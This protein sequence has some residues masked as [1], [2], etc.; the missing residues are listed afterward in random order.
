[1][2]VDLTI[3][4]AGLLL[5]GGAFSNKISSRFNLPALLLFL[6]A[7]VLADMILPVDMLSHADMVNT[8]GIVAMSY[9]LYSGGMETDLAAV[10]RVMRPGLLLAGPGVMLTALLLGSC[11]YLVFGSSK[12][13]LWCL[14]LG[15]LIS[16]TDA[17]AVFAI[18]R[19]RGVGLKRDLQPLL[20]LE[21]GSNDPMAV[22]LTVV[23]VT[24]IAGGSSGGV[25][26]LPLAIY[27]LG[28]GIFFGWLLGR[29][30][31]YLFKVKL[32]Y[33]GLYF[34]VSV[35]LVLVCYGLSQALMANGFMACYVCG[36]IMGNT[37]YYY[38]NGLCKFHNGFAWLMQVGLFIVLGF[39]VKPVEL[40]TDAEVWTR[41]VVLGLLLMFLVRPLSV[42]CCLTG[43]GYSFKEKIFISWVGI[44]GAAPIVLATFPLAFGVEDADLLF[45]LIF[46]MVLL[47]V[48]LQG[49]L[50]MPVA[51]LLELATDGAEKDEPPPLALEITSGTS[52]QDMREFKVRKKSVLAG[53]SLAQIALPQGVLVTMIRRKGEFIA[54][55][56][57]TVI[58]V[59]DGLLMMAERKML[60]EVEGKYFAG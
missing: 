10:K 31:K 23:L 5:L 60:A 6:G 12:P 17:A 26:E 28:G 49:W 40:F 7:G 22:S 8:F 16:S 36:V 4:I 59:G 53:K 42:F 57:D 56:G 14:L 58:A 45:K 24:A 15:A 35:A 30:G 19:G 20:E 33:E 3:A 32:E 34:V 37:R 43:S 44:R 38:K 46:F 1:M 18:L 55:R 39:M 21:S 41:G 25:W 2:S 51:R 9:I 13:F 50:L 47:S 48:L 29:F 27:R 11:A 52:H 54:P